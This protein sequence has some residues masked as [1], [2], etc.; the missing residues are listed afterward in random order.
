[1]AIKGKSKRS[2]GRPVRRPATGPRIQTVARRLPC[3]G[4]SR[5]SARALLG[6]LVHRGVLRRGQLEVEAQRR[7]TGAAGG[8]E[9]RSA[10]LWGLG[11]RIFLL[12]DGR[13]S[14]LL[15]AIQAHASA[16][17]EANVV[18]DNFNHLSPDTL[19]QDLLNFLRSL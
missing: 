16:G 13:T 7:G 1:M 19:K 4:R 10:P 5:K 14:D 17:S 3:R 18:I 9:F 8:D 15:Q 2:Q 12:H 11:Q 6:R